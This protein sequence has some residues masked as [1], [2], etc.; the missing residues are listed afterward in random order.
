MRRIFEIFD[1]FSGDLRYSVATQIPTRRWP[2]RYQILLSCKS[3][4]NRLQAIFSA[5][6]LICY[7]FIILATLVSIYTISNILRLYLSN[8]GVHGSQVELSLTQLIELHPLE[9]R[10]ALKFIVNCFGYSCIFVPGILIYQYTKKIKYLERCG[11]KMT[12][13]R[14]FPFELCFIYEFMNKSIKNIS[15]KHPKKC[16]N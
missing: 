9:Y 13:T 4:A 15:Q 3:I 16:H 5:I 7:S 12:S 14:L 2:I 1:G 8:D 11:K 10:W 6:L